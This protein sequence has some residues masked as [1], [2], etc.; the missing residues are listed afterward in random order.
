MREK[1]RVVILLFISMVIFMINIFVEYNKK[2]NVIEA[3]NIDNKKN[4]IKYSILIILAASQQIMAI[5]FFVYLLVYLTN[6]KKT[7]RFAT[8]LVIINS[9]ACKYILHSFFI[10]KIFQII[11][12][13]NTKKVKVCLAIKEETITFER[14]GKRKKNSE[15]DER[16]IQT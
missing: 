6:E 11:L 3:L 7:L 8:L 16:Q 15:R 1:N 9:V 14:R 13:A 4:L 5:V 10:Q 2:N 12:N